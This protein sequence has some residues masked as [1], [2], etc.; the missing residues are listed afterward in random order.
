MASQAVLDLS[1]SAQA[2]FHERITDASKQLRVKLNDDVEFYLVNL[3]TEFINPD[4]LNQDFEPQTDILATPLVFLLKQTVEAPESKRPVMYRRLGDAS[5]YIAGYFQD[6]FNDKTFDINYFITM[7][8][9]AYNQAALLLKN[10]AKDSAQHPETLESLSRN[11]IQVVDVVAQAS[12]TAGPPKA[13]DILH[14]YDR[15]NRCGSERLRNLLQEHGITPV[16]VPLKL[17]Q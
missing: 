11:F 17:A 9:S 12:D 15:W 13:T 16:S 3:L 6:Y 4:R 2:F 1:L 5:L 7:G 10:H 14:I 8:A